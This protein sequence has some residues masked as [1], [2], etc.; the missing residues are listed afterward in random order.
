ME[1]PPGA[2]ALLGAGLVILTISL[3]PLLGNEDLDGVSMLWAPL[4]L[5]N[6]AMI[7]FLLKLARDCPGIWGKRASGHVASIFR[8]AVGIILGYFVLSTTQRAGKDPTLLLSVS[9]LDECFYLMAD[10][11]QISAACLTWVPGF[12]TVTEICSICRWFALTSL[13]PR[14]RLNSVASSAAPSVKNLD[15]SAFNGRIVLDPENGLRA[16]QPQRGSSYQSTEDVTTA[17]SVEGTI[18][19]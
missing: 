1:N 4:I 7:L 17:T 15:S 5:T 11:S 16:N 12:L 10:L 18:G 3:T 8:A 19:C 6:V 9:L 14:S 13:S 2:H